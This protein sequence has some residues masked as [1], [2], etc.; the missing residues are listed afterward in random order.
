VSDLN[1]KL[2][3]WAQV[4]KKKIEGVTSELFVK[5]TRGYYFFY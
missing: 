2:D 3:V 1:E 4:V 5:A